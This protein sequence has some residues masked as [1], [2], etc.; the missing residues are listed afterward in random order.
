MG[1]PLKRQAHLRVPVISTFQGCALPQIISMI[2]YLT[3][4]YGEGISAKI[5]KGQTKKE[6]KL[7]G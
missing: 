4:V 2:K 1:S 5:R 6:T 7:T 3:E